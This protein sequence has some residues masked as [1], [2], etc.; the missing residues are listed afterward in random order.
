M[1]EKNACKNISEMTVI[2]SVTSDG[3]FDPNPK[4]GFS[5]V[6]APSFPPRTI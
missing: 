6:A 1:K 4:A 3:T 5:I 2:Q